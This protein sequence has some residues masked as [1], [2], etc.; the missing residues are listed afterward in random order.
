MRK[1]QQ[2]FWWIIIFLTE[3]N[4]YVIIVN[5][6][7]IYDSRF[8]SYDCVFCVKICDTVNCVSLLITVKI[9]RDN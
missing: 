8:Y 7:M 5:A 2:K 4:I 6:L 9:Y 3:W 1:T